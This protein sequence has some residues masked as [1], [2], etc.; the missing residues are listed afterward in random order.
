MPS[1]DLHG[2]LLHLTIVTV[3]YPSYFERYVRWLLSLT[4]ITYLTKLIGTHSLATFLQL[5]LF[6]V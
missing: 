1:A 3:F 5:E 6:W 2:S 4:Q